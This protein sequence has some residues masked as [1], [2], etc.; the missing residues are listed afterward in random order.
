MPLISHFRAG[1]SN[2]CLTCLVLGLMRHRVAGKVGCAFRRWVHRVSQN[3]GVVRAVVR[4]GCFSFCAR[5]AWALV[6][7]TSN[8]V[9]PLSVFGLMQF[10]QD[11][12]QVLTSLYLAR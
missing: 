3:G 1:C 6:L 2:W 8:E 7:T 9:L 10:A 4:G 12:C 11:C 5:L